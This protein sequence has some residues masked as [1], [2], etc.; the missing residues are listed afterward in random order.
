M[1]ADITVAFLARG[2]D[3]GLAAVEAFLAS[4]GRY[5]AGTSHSLVLLAK[6]W[7]GVSGRERLSDLAAV[8]G[9]E[10]LDLSD[11]GYDWG[12]Y[13]R[14]SAVAKTEY[15][16]LLNTHSR[17]M[18][19]GWV[20]RPYAQ[21][22]RPE[23][24]LVGCTASWGSIGWNW[25]FH[26]YHIKRLWKKDWRVKSIAYAAWVGLRYLAFMLSRQ[27]QF[28]DFPNPHVRSNAFM[29]RT[30]HLR[31]FAAQHDMP[32]T[33]HQAHL[34]ECGRNGLSRFIEA[35]G[36]GLLLCG[37]DGG[38]HPPS[39]WPESGIFCC[40]NQPNLLVADNLTQE[41]E[42][43]TA[44]KK[45]DLELAFWGRVLTPDIDKP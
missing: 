24:G 12:A 17:I 20:A 31:E 28:P 34:L 42:N 15:L 26:S 30:A 35:K 40:P 36:L 19:D 4:Y 39:S 27:R 3:G 32:N 2:I 11:E 38:A 8:A 7:E 13:F 9:A 43:R 1:A 16:Y 45:R 6:G 21:I 10:V 25:A 5:A 14:L 44:A 18:R 23:I 41:Y 33:K 22:T 37:A 29:L